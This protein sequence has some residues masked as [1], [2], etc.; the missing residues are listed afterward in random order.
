M[1]TKSITNPDLFKVLNASTHKTI[2]GCDQEWYTTKWQR[3]SGC[4][5]TAASSIIF[6]L[7]NS[8]SIFQLEQGTNSNE[9]CL[10][11]MEEVWKYVTP[12]KEGIPTTKMFYEAMLVYTKSK[13]MNVKYDFCDLPKDISKRPKLSKVLDFLEEALVN[14]A[15]IAFLNLCNGMEKKLQEW[16]WVT[17]ISLEY[18][19]NRNTAFIKILDE[20]LIKKIDLA[21][22]YNTTTLG[23]GFVY[24]IT[25]PIKLINVEYT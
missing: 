15:P 5:P 19:E 8:R 7:N 6:Y 4:G 21:L 9:N 14:D 24:F 22:W 18:S 12:T 3:Q 10:S 11:L 20:G 2:Y 23:G 13:G 25:L 16:H 17:I 1:I